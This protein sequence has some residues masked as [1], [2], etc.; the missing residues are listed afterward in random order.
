MNQLRKL[1]QS[2]LLRRLLCLQ[3]NRPA[4]HPDSRSFHQLV[5]GQDDRR[6]NQQL[7]SVAVRSGLIQQQRRFKGKKAGKG[8]KADDDES[9]SESDSEEESDTDS[10][11]EDS[12]TENS[13][14]KKIETINTRLDMMMKH[15]RRSK[16]FE[17]CF[18]PRLLLLAIRQTPN[19]NGR[20]NI[21]TNL[22]FLPKFFTKRSVAQSTMSNRCSTK[23][24]C[25]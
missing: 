25:E 7:V 9:D 13:N 3:A 18:S 23:T 4:S 24:R 20:Q 12:D 22:D 21:G 5:N 15:G 11:E 14:I 17:F 2:N 6:R 16:C 10:S 8:K 1:Q 19:R